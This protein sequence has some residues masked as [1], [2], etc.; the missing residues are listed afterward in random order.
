MKTS[1]S[2]EEKR[3]K[4]YRARKRVILI[5]KTLRNVVVVGGIIFFVV[6]LYFLLRIGIATE[7]PLF[8][9][10]SSSSDFDPLGRNTPLSSHF[11]ARS[12]TK[13]SLPLTTKE[14]ESTLTELQKEL[15]KEREKERKKE[16]EESETSFSTTIRRAHLQRKEKEVKNQ[17]REK[18]K[19][20]R[21]IRFS[22]REKKRGRNSRQDQLQQR[23]FEETEEISPHKYANN[24][25]KGTLSSKESSFLNL[26]KREKEKKNNL[27]SQKLLNARNYFNKHFRKYKEKWSGQIKSSPS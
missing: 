7:K 23:N 10:T 13:S 17:K 19:N 20:E 26:R 8:L 12:S 1:G 15:Q 21:T 9:P 18:A 5:P 16:R 22:Q 6:N 25:Q 4:M 11:K 24:K 14:E 2:L 27:E 3:K